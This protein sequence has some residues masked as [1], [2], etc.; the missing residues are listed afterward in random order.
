[1]EYNWAKYIT[2]KGSSRWLTETQ[3]YFRGHF[4]IMQCMGIIIIIIN[5]LKSLDWGVGGGAQR[6]CKSGDI[7][8]CFMK[9]ISF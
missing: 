7:R 6:T 5:H 9:K 4:F 2:L 1:M 8:T 3:W